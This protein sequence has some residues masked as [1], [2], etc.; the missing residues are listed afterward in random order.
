VVGEIGWCS[1][2]EY[3]GFLFVDG[4]ENTGIENRSLKPWVDSYKQNNVSIFDHFN[5]GVEKV[6]SSEVVGNVEVSI[7]SEL[8]VE[9]VECVEEIF[10][11]L[12]VL[13]TFEFSY[14]AGNIVT[15]YLFN[16]GSD[17]SQ[18]IFP[19]IFSK[20]SSFSDEGYS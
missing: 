19:I 6:V 12:N 1:D 20:I 4:L 14:S 9:A 8:I 15:I 3:F 17:V 2:A 16:F 18:S 10:Q 5:L 11:R 13:N 7:M